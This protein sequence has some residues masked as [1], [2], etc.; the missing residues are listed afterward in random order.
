MNLLRD[1]NELLI[2][3]NGEMMGM[4]EQLSGLS[5]EQ[6]RQ[7]RDTA[8]ELIA[9]REQEQTRVVW[10]LEDRHSRI[11]AFSDSDYVK[12]AEAL[13][14]QARVNA[15]RPRPMSVGQKELHLVAVHVPES[16]YSDWVDVQSGATPAAA[17]YSPGATSA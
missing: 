5:L 7:A 16:E 10:C 14:A 4:R 15:A 6:L 3:N 11:Q 1:D 9:A 8:A 17:P 2:D 12:A 13:L